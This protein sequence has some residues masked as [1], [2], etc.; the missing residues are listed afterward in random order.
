VAFGEEAEVKLMTFVFRFGYEMPQQEAANAAR[1]W[2]DESS[3]WI[4]IEA[5]DE[6]AAL[7]WGREVAERFVRELG[8]GSWRA[9]SFAHWVEPP[10]VCPWAVGRPVVAVGQFPDFGGWV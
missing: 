2:D 10:A 6:G 8:C 9:G 5:P 1:G 7:A 4:V 3:Q